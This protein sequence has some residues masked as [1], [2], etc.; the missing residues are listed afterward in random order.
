MKYD[1]FSSKIYK[2][3]LLIL[4]LVISL[5]FYSNLYSIW[6]S[7]PGINVFVHGEEEQKGWLLWADQSRFYEIS[8]ALIEGNFDPS[9]YIYSIGYPIVSTPFTWLDFGG[10]YDHRF[11]IPNILMFL[12]VVYALYKLTLKTTDRKEF[13]V[14]SVLLLL[15]VT[16]YVYSFQEPQT[17]H[18]TSFGSIVLLLLLFNKVE[19]ID[20]RTIIF[21]SLI[22]GWIF[23][24][25]FQDVFFFIPLVSVFFIHKPK[26]IVW[27]FPLLIIVLSVFGLNT[28]IFSDPFQVPHNFKTEQWDVPELKPLWEKTGKFST[29]PKVFLHRSYCILIDPQAC[30][31]EPTGS[32]R[33]D[34]GNYYDFIHS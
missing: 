30:L 14:I 31:M 19:N 2:H 15:F 4:M 8:T 6:P 27:M 25:R 17:T 11:L 29:D 24:S 16:N 1:Q 33:A 3:K 32:E 26:K 21:V 18:V 34:K 9:I 12:I 13:A 10:T 28:L 20:R 22:L 23:A 5:L 7:R